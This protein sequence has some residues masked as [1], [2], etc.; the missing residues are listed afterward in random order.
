MVYRSNVEDVRGRG[1]WVG[2]EIDPAKADAHHICEILMKNGLLT[3]E[4][5]KTVIRLAPPLVIT[6]EILNDAIA[7]IAAT[8][9]EVEAVK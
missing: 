3:K 7:I 1:L 8:L 2:V 6:K 9:K 5:H 4:T